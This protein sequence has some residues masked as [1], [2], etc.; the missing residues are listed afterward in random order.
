[1]MVFGSPR[2]VLPVPPYFEEPD[3]YYDRTKQTAEVMVDYLAT[4][5]WDM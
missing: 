3:R 1:M 2:S 4:N 5:H